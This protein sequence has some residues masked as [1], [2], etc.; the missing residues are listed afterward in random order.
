MVIT[1]SI[2]LHA[3]GGQYLTVYMLYVN[4]ILRDDTSEPVLSNYPHERPP[5]IKERHVG[6][7][8]HL[9]ADLS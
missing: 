7:Y 5:V 9:N 4:E 1:D 3:Q 8:G 2:L 6:G